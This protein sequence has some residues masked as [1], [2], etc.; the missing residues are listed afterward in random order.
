MGY[1]KWPACPS[2]GNRL[3][4]SKVEHDKW[5]CSGAKG[6]NSIFTEHQV[7]PQRSLDDFEKL[8]RKE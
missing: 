4:L 7:I 2:C 6:C 8:E 5:I 1:F 3:H